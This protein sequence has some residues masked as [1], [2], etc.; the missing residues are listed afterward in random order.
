MDN[1]SGKQP[2][3]F[4]RQN[5]VILLYLAIACGVGAGERRECGMTFDLI[6]PLINISPLINSALI[7]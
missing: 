6:N 7:N 3:K 2:V 4:P 1:G 5:D